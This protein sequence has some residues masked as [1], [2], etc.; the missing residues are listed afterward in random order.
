VAARSSCISVVVSNLNGGPYLARLLDTL[1]AQDDVE[2]EVIVVDRHSTDASEEILGR[3]PAVRVLHE[4]PESGLVAGYSV[5]ANA[6]SNPLLFFCNEDLYL[7]RR[8]LRELA[9]RIDLKNRIAACDP[10]EWSYDGKRWIRGGVRYRRS[11]WQICSPY[12]FRMHEC[13]VSLPDRSPVPFGCAGAM[14]VHADVYEQLG[15]WDT[16]FFLDYEDIDFFLRAWQRDWICVTVPA[17]R[18]FHR[19][20]ASNEQIVGARRMTVGRRRY[21]SN[22]A[23]TA[24]VAFKYFSLPFSVL[25]ALNWVATLLAHVLLLRRRTVWL[26]LLVVGDIARRMP[27]VI[28]FRR[29]NRRWNRSKPGERFFLDPRFSVDRLDDVVKE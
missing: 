29:R 28:A 27:G 14:M 4:R 10:W 18:V 20:G 24:V 12:P 21:V 7:D 15:G 16:S 11:L 9:L 25:G 3:Y 26:D 22:R 23:G 1:D 19:V 8:C 6:A 2:T 13:T 17:A 5:G